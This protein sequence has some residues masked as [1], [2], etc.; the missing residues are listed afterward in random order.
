MTQTTA[1]P[2]LQ[3]QQYASLS[4]FRKSGEAVATPVWFALEGGKL[5]IVTM[6]K[7]GKTKR[8]RN[9]PQ[10]QLAPCT[11][12]GKLLGP[13]VDGTARVLSASEGKLADALLLKKYGLFY[14]GFGLMWRI[15]RAEV[16]YLEV[17][18]V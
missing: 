5:Y 10:V 7:A 15:Q 3:G 12:A 8:I 1:F 11:S 14:R 9:N 18:P 4:T 13:S 16:A 17:S 6:A 2:N